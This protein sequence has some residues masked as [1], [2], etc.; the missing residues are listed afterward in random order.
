M[1]KVVVNEFISLDGVAQAPGGAEEDTTGGFKHGGWSMEYMDEPAQEWVLHY[2]AAA[3]GFLLGR[4]TFEIFAGYWPNASEEERVIADPL[5]SKP[6][7]VA[8]T[9]LSE[10]LQWETLRSFRETWPMP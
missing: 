3:G 8:S 9:T 2:L 10:P 1:R 5:N 7:F 4:V 6:K